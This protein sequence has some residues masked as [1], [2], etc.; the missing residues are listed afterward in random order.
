MGRGIERVVKKGGGGECEQR[1]AMSRG[2]D[3]ERGERG[4]EG[5]GGES[6]QESKSI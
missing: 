5:V 4:R 1:P 3:R 6:V 2:R